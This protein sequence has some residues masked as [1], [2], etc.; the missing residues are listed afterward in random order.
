MYE[1]YEIQD[2]AGEEMKVR[3]GASIN[4]VRVSNKFVHKMKKTIKE[5]EHKAKTWEENKHWLDATVTLTC[6]NFTDEGITPELFVEANV[7]WLGEIV[8]NLRKKVA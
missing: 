6:N 5:I 8:E 4:Y 3:E 2:T 1:V 7:F